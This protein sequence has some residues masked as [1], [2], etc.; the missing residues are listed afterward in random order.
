[1]ATASGWQL[2]RFSHL[3][4]IAPEAWRCLIE[5]T[6]SVEMDLKLTKNL[7]QMTPQQ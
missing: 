6:Q 1:V 3:P 4:L 7:E 5:L 2:A